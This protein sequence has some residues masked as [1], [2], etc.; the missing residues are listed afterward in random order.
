M[1]PALSDV[2]KRQGFDPLDCPSPP[3]RKEWER[4]PIVAAIRHAEKVTGVRYEP[5]APANDCR[6]TWA[7]GILR[8][9]AETKGVVSERDGDLV[10]LL[11]DLQHWCDREEVDFETALHTARLHFQSDK[12]ADVGS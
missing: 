5:E 12:S 4:F 11:T 7:A 2:I 10:D 9:Y 3:I 1:H 8:L 6:A